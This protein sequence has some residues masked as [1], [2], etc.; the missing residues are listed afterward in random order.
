MSDPIARRRRRVSASTFGALVAVG[1]LSAC[2]TAV[3]GAAVAAT[4]DNGTTDRTTT[5]AEPTRIAPR[6]TTPR[7]TVARPTT[8]P[9]GS[10]DAEV[11]DCVQLGGD[12]GAPSI[13]HAP[14][15]TAAANFK[16]VE[17]TGNHL[18]CV[19]DADAWYA[20]TRNGSETEAFCLDIDW[21]A[22][23]C[24]QT[25]GDWPT[26]VD[27]AAPPADTVRVASISTG[28][29]TSHCASD[30]GVYSERMIVICIEAV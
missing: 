1:L 14:C 22:G 29:D 9:A 23:D 21:V 19:S 2:G 4:G 27:C 3:T 26:R 12:A 16:V 13:A 25:S 10:F 6:T 18:D 15:G 30:G 24:F 17:K 7:T 28:T 8:A 20:N 5:A 11:G